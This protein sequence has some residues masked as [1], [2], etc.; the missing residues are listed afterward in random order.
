MYTGCDKVAKL[1][2]VTNS[3]IGLYKFRKELI[4][5]LINAKHSVTISAPLG[6][7]SKQFEDMGC[8][9]VHSEI[10]RR[11]M[12]PLKDFRLYRAYRK[13]IQKVSPD[14][15]LTY[16]IK[17][18]IYGGIAAKKAKVPYIA[19]ITGLGTGVNKDSFLKRAL[20]VL[21]RYALNKVYT[22]FVQNSENYEFLSKHSIGKNRLTLIPGSGVN[23]EEYSSMPYP[24]STTIRFLF[25]GRLMREKGINEYLQAAQ[26]I[27]T[28]HDN[29][30]FHICGSSEEDYESKILDLS[31]QGVVKFH[32]RVSNVQ[33]MYKSVHC[34]VHPSYHEGMSNAL[35]EAAATAR[36]ILAS[37]IAGCR[38]IFDEGVSGYGFARKN[39]EAI[40]EVME[41]FIALPH[42][43]KETMGRKARQKVVES[44]DR[45]IVVNA[46]KEAIESILEDSS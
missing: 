39:S 32:G 24:S 41:K 31:K 36:P 11:G 38:E 28:K 45:N 26:I 34:I 33:E 43:E 16:T 7:K 35:L 21:Y 23:I 44:F 20:I 37:D 2:F 42:S 9:V 25:V 15:V 8:H 6:N 12:N 4:E 18:N 14:V 22:V 40:V 19:N 17:P 30:E 13:T 46:Y 3:I 10:D 27:K 1:L 29:V 5:S